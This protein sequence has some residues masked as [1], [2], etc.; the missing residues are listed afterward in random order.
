MRHGPAVLVLLVAVATTASAEEAPAPPHRA[1]PPWS[2]PYVL[3][4]GPSP[5]ELDAIERSGRRKRT[6]GV[7]LLT[8][9]GGLMVLGAALTVAG[10][11]DDDDDCVGRFRHSDVRWGHHDGCGNASLT[12]AGVSTAI[13]G[14][15]AL[16]A[17]FPLYTIGASQV[18]HA[19]ELRRYMVLTPSLRASPRGASISLGASF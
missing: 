14:S 19:R 8:S 4:P 5:A 13:I 12:Y 18:A 10:A 2:S 15:A 9:G 3:V 11:L 1:P 7:A 16:L 6:A 17:G